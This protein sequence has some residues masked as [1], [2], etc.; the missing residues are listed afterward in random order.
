VH[1]RARHVT[2]HPNQ[3]SALSYAHAMGMAEH[4]VYCLEQPHVAVDDG[5]H[6]D[7]AFGTETEAKAY[8]ERANARAGRVRFRHLDLSR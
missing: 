1:R 6:G 3:T 4:D 7:L 8:V 2:R 5:G